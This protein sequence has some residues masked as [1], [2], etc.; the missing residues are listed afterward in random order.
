M[1]KK[2]KKW[3]GLSWRGERGM[4][5]AAARGR[6]GGRREVGGPRGGPGAFVL[7]GSEVEVVQ[8]ASVRCPSSPALRADGAFLDVRAVTEC[9]GARGGWR[10]GW[11]ERVR[12]A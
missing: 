7:A 11:L 4:E 3:E 10:A 9:G 1:S 8:P 6:A 12:G 2:K 5:G